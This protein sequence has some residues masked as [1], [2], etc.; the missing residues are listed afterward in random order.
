V[1]AAAMQPETFQADARQQP[2]SLAATVCLNL[3][4]RIGIAAHGS[5]HSSGAQSR[6]SDPPRMGGDSP[7]PGQG[8]LRALTPRARSRREAPCCRALDG[9]SFGPTRTNCRGVRTP[10]IITAPPSIPRIAPR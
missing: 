9:Q 2:S 1:S 4:P 10:S 3:R 8:R 6:N 7:G 5:A